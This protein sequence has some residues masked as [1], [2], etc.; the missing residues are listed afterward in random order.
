MSARITLATAGR[1]LSQLRRDRR[2]LGMVF[3][4]PSVLIALLA[5]MLD[6]QQE[7]FD[8]VGTPIVGLFPLIVMFLITSIAMLRERS[9]GTLER[10]MSLPLS[11]LD[12]LGGYGLAFAGL[13]ALQG[14]VTSAV[15]FGLLGVESKGP[16]IAVVALA[17]ANALVGMAL[18]LFTSAFARSEFQAVQFL[19]AVVFPQL[20]LAGLFVPRSRMPGGLQTL[21]DVLPITYAYEALTKVAVN[22][23]AGR[24]W[25]DVAVIAVT[26]GTCLLL[27]AATLRRQTP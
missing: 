14:I 16:V 22:D 11:K 13:A 21:S 25:I 19:P 7:T 3:V 5:L 8:R 6:N 12:L 23:I 4:V 9:S 10:L 2:T 20:L 24:F 27:G 26:I 15:A 17:I 1:V 18:G